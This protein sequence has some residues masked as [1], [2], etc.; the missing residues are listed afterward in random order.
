MRR[1]PGVGPDTAWNWQAIK[2]LEI[3]NITST[4]SFVFLWCCLCWPSC[5]LAVIRFDRLADCCCPDNAA[6]AAVF[7]VSPC[8]LACMSRL[9]AAILHHGSGLQ[10]RCCQRHSWPRRQSVDGATAVRPAFSGKK[11]SCLVRLSRAQGR[12]CGSAEGLFARN[13]AARVTAGSGCRM[14]AA[15]QLAGLRK[16][17]NHLTDSVNCVWEQV[18]ECG[19]AGR[20]AALPAEVGLPALRGHLLDKGQRQQAGQGGLHPPGLPLHPAA[21]Q[22]AGLCL[23]VS[24]SSSLSVGGA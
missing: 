3:E 17:R 7:K 22:G 19:G 20:G 15:P 10:P 12:R 2:A 11:T 8:M 14:Q 6:C 5:H 9:I 21:H 18:W 24:P 4:P 23:Q 1:A 16:A 13:A